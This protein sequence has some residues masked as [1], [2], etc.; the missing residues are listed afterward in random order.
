MNTE[1]NFRYWKSF[2][3]ASVEAVLFA[4]GDPSFC[5]AHGIMNST[6]IRSICAL[7]LEGDGGQKGQQDEATFSGQS[8]RIAQNLLHLCRYAPG[9]WRRR[10]VSPLSYR[11]GTTASI[12]MINHELQ[13]STCCRIPAAVR[14]HCAVPRDSPIW[15]SHMDLTCGDPTTPYLSRCH[16]LYRFA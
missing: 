11:F 14:R 9:I 13:R 10:S 8:N 6:S 1:N 16:R 5:S 3:M 15:R 4:S 12:C 7:L 2:T